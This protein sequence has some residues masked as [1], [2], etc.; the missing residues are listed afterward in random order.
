VILNLCLHGAAE[1]V[2]VGDGHGVY[3]EKD[4]TVS[5]VTRREGYQIKIINRST[6]ETFC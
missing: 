4:S 6:I 3:N 5:I 1:R 2:T